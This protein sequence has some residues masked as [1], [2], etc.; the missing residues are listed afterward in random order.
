MGSLRAVAG[1]LVRPS[2]GACGRD[3][4]SVGDGVIRVR[5]AQRG[6]KGI[7]QEA[8]RFEVDATLALGARN[9]T[10]GAAQEPDIGE[11]DRT[12]SAPDS[13]HRAPDGPEPASTSSPTGFAMIER[14]RQKRG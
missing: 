14:P 7:G 6:V 10:S 1:P 11:L 12:C 2:S 13:L 4:E 9:R 8:D 3:L 5:E